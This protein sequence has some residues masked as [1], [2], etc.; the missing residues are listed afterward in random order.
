MILCAACRALVEEAI[1]ARG[2]KDNVSTIIVRLSANPQPQGIRPSS[3]STSDEVS[4]SSQPVTSTTS[5]IIPGGQHGTEGGNGLVIRSASSPMRRGSSEESGDDVESIL[6]ELGSSN[7]DDTDVL[8]GSHQSP[9]TP[10]AGG[11][12]GGA[13]ARSSSVSSPAASE[14]RAKARLAR[15]LNLEGEEDTLDFLLDDGN[16]K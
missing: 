5:F 2:S 12:G 4:R 3:Y 9:Q 1:H 16:F 14:D 15:D 7:D 13:V 10:G 6:R 8:L 11:G